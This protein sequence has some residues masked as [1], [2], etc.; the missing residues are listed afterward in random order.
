MAEGVTA[1]DEAGAERAFEDLRAEV[2][3]LRRL[4]EALPGAW[5]AVRP[6]PPPD[7]GPDLARLVQTMA[8]IG[9]RLRAIEAKPALSRNPENDSDKLRR[10]GEAAVAGAVQSLDHE[11]SQL[12]A[13]GET[14]AKAATEL[15]KP[16]AARRGRWLWS[17]PTLLVGLMASPFL[18]SFL[19]FNWNQVVAAVV[20]GTDRWNA[21]T[22]LMRAAAPQTW[23]MLVD[24]WHLI[25]INKANA[26]SLAQCQKQ[27]DEIHQAQ[28]CRIT[29]PARE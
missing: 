26:Q 3:V 18:A 22:T 16:K 17:A 1:A 14:L 8:A 4:I 6:T 7:Y 20:M 2:S 24:D 12:K 23:N 9:E 5:Q 19:P 11:T 28:E 10:A 29:V 13:A 27:A 21:G 25:S 15:R